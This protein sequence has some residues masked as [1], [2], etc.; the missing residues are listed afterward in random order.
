MAESCLWGQPNS[1]SNKILCQSLSK[2]NILGVKIC[3]LGFSEIVSN[4]RRYK[5]SK[6]NWLEFWVKFII[7][8][9]R[10]LCFPWY[11]C[12]VWARVSLSHCTLFSTFTPICWIWWN[13]GIFCGRE[14]EWGISVNGGTKLNNHKE[15]VS[16]H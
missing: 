11:L 4:D 3:L 7:C 5:V 1:R 8:R 9:K 12:R 13:L 15:G 16:Y 14:Y 10:M 2:I 6:V